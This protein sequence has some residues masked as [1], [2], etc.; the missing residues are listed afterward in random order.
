MKFDFLLMKIEVH[1]GDRDQGQEMV[2]T[3]Q[4]IIIF[5]SCHVFN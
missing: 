1:Y 5:F 2:E 3:N 4:Q